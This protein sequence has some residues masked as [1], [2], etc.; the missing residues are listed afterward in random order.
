MVFIWSSILCHGVLLTFSLLLSGMYLLDLPSCIT[1]STC[2]S[3][4]YHGVILAL[5]LVLWYQV[6]LLSSIYLT[7]HLVQYYSL[8]LSSCMAVAWPFMFHVS[9]Y[10]SYIIVLTHWSRG[11]MDAISQTT[12]WS[13]FSWMKMFEFRWKFHWSLFLKVQLTIFQH[14]FR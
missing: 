2:P 6:D 7:F 13:A 14:W 11:K 1:V 5:H 10:T 4:L 12:F 9:P 3:I 8:A